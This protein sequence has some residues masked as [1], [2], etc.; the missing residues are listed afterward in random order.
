MGIKCLAVDDEPLALQQIVSYIEKTPF[1]ELINACNSGIEALSILN[2]EN[3]Q[4]LF[5]DINMPDLNGMELVK[6]LQIKPFIVFTTAYAEFA[7]E[8]FKVSALD[9]LL[10]PIGY[11]DFLKAANKAQMAMEQQQK[12]M[13]ISTANAIDHIFVKADYKLMR[14]NLSEIKFI[15]SMHEYVRIHLISEQPIMSLMS[16][17]AIEEML[18]IQQF[19]RVHRSFIVNLSQV[20]IVEKNRIVFDKTYIPISDNYKDLFQE[21]IDGK[22]GK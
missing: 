15:E 11:T 18:P 20:K 2:K 1:L 7:V 21:F 5:I 14:I 16:L 10:K 3:I 13:P 12:T 22:L 6:A 8:G 4:L 17:K 19:M 9:Y